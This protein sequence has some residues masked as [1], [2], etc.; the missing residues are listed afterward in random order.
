MKKWFSVYNSSYSCYMNYC[1][2][3]DDYTW[4]SCNGKDKAFAVIKKIRVNTYRKKYSKRDDTWEKKWHKI[5]QKTF[6]IKKKKRKADQK[7]TINVECIPVDFNVKCSLGASAKVTSCNGRPD[8][9]TFISKGYT[10]RNGYAFKY[11]IINGLLMCQ[12]RYKDGYIKY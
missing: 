7:W 4:Y 11:E 6:N 1:N 10:I 9:K 12:D 2:K 3:A 8:R 5:K